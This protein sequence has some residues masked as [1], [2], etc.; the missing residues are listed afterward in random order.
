M[1]VYIREVAGEYTTVAGTAPNRH[2]YQ[3]AN[4]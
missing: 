1:K 3:R 4:P 2:Q